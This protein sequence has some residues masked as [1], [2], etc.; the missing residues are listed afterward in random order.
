[1]E[2]R[3]QANIRENNKKIIMRIICFV[4]LI[5]FTILLYSCNKK[6]VA[7][8]DE[9]SQ[10][11]IENT[12]TI[13][14]GVKIWFNQNIDIHYS[15]KK[16][17]LVIAAKDEE[18]IGIIFDNYLQR[19]ID[20]IAVYDSLF[21]KTYKTVVNPNFNVQGKNLYWNI[22]MPPVN[23]GMVVLR[24]NNVSFY[25]IGAGWIG[26]TPEYNA[27]GNLLFYK[28]NENFDSIQTNTLP[29][30]YAKW[31]IDAI[32]GSKIYAHDDGVYSQHIRL[33]TSSDLGTT[34]NLFIDI[35]TSI[36]GSGSYNLG[37]FFLDDTHQWFFVYEDWERTRI[38][39]VIDGTAAEVSLLQGF[40][41]K[42][43][44]FIDELNGFIFA[45]TND[46]VSPSTAQDSY[47]F[48]TTDGGETW[49]T[50]VLV[51][52]TDPPNRLWVFD[53]NNLIVTTSQP[54]GFKFFYKSTDGG[55]TWN[56][57]NIEI[58]EYICSITFLN[59]SLGFLKTGRTIL[60]SQYN[61]GYVYKTNNGG[62]SWTKVSTSKEYGSKIYFNDE[63]NGYMQ[64][65]LYDQGQILL[66][67]KDG[68]VTWEELLYPYD[69]ISE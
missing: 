18:S 57:N 33:M 4:L 19:I 49:G 30:Q 14:F 8:D 39:K 28:A 13:S 50:P 59:T 23:S 1:M 37:G 7:P 21:I 41:L 29:A 6:I 69:Y 36:F 17:S 5:L 35:S 52:S 60:W 48:R 65:L 38:F 45:N 15:D 2:D 62:I 12:N 3:L 34:W 68:G 51:S 47:I 16:D 26:F 9:A 11:I 42:Q 66:I 53:A 20:S 64:D 31:V 22:K 25:K 10:I 56:K 55:A 67:T 27:S 58:N 43:C 44:K 63:S 24:N 61:T 32:N 46:N 54:E 40:C